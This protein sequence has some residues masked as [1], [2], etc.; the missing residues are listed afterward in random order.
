MD[1]SPPGSSVQGILQQEYWS[2]LPCASPGDL[3]G[4]GIEP[5]SLMSPTLTDGVFTT[6]A[7]REVHSFMYSTFNR[8]LCVDNKFHILIYCFQS[9]PGLATKLTI[10][11]MNSEVRGQKIL[12][13]HRTLWV[14]SHLPNLGLKF[15]VT[16]K[17]E[18]SKLVSKAPPC[19]RDPIVLCPLKT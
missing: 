15:L 11:K 6:S 4:P 14:M 17:R 5:T 1:C 12:R 8:Y 10:I 19:S 18:P 2:G 3:P 16:T 7:T 13:T 9:A